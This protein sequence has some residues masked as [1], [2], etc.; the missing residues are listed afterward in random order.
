MPTLRKKRNNVYFVDYRLG[1]RRYRRCL[2]TRNPAIAKKKYRELC[3]ELELGI[4]RP[5]TKTKVSEFI[6]KF[7][8]H[9]TG[10]RKEKTVETQTRHLRLFLEQVGDLRLT[11]LRPLHV[12]TFL[13]EHA[14]NPGTWNRYR[15]T[16]HKFLQH[17]VLLDEIP[18]NPAS[19]VRPQREEKKPP[20]FL[21]IEDRD[22]LI[23][24]ARGTSLEVP[25]ALG[26][27]AG[28][29]REEICRLQWPD[30]DLDRLSLTV[31]QAKS[32]RFRVV[33]VSANLAEI[34]RRA[35]KN[36]T[37]F[38]SLRGEK[39][40]DPDNLTHYVRKL[41]KHLGLE[42]NLRGTHALRETFAS[43]LA[44]AGENLYQIKEWLGH[45]SIAVT[46]RYAHLLPGR[47]GKI[48]EV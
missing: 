4:H 8:K 17:A 19:K 41:G 29:R 35:R 26:A 15:T 44:M 46:E 34:L 33:P 22:R 27:L 21:T 14:K 37:P 32:K 30:V 10:K 48:D 7:L 2:N 16:I 40:W 6:A 42:E 45:S 23:A 28:L 3:A 36:D 20:R 25:I 5:P 11:D 13:D 18:A 31:R 39:P 38:V 9:Q 47:R 43:L 1:A 12:T 24:E